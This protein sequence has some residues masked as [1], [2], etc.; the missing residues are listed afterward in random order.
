MHSAAKTKKT[1]TRIH[2]IVK[3]LDK[4][5]FI[6]LVKM[7]KFE[8]NLAQDIAENKGYIKEWEDSNNEIEAKELLLP[9]TVRKEY[10]NLRDIILCFGSEIS[11]GGKSDERLLRTGAEIEKTKLRLLAQIEKAV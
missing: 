4:T 6:V 11:R 9:K 3:K 1:L 8:E 10:Y 2:Y 7:A 5:A